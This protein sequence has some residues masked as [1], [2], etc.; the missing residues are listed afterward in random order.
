MIRVVRDN[1]LIRPL[2]T[3]EVSEGGIIVPEHMRKPGCKVEI[4]AVGPGVKGS[5]MQFKPGQIAFRT[6]DAGKESEL[7]EN[8]VQY[9]IVN[10]SW[11]LATLN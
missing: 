2:P 3:D 1:V 11:L 8:G 6:K 10:Q 7:W 4:V 9:F 5:P